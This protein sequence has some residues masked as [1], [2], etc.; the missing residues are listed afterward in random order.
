MHGSAHAK[1]D[2]EIL[3]VNFMIINDKY[4]KDYDHRPVTDAKGRFKDEFYY[5]GERTDLNMDAEHKKKAGIRFLLFGAA[6]FCAALLPGFVEHAA[7]RVL[8]VM[9]PWACCF[10]PSGYFLLGAFEFATNGTSLTRREYDHSIERMRN[11]VWGIIFLTVVNLVVA[12]IYSVMHF[13]MSELL[14]TA[15]FLPLA[16]VAFV[17]TKQELLKGKK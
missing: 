1:L 12:I 10:L 3:P 15:S 6:M 9:V 8:W 7:S 17:C 4:K 16:V 5:T 11:S 14:Y 2:S 13:D